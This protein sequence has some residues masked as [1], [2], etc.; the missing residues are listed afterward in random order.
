[1]QKRFYVRPKGFEPLTDGLENRCSIQLSYGRIGAQKY[2]NAANKQTKVSILFKE[3]Q[4]D[5][6]CISTSKT[7]RDKICS[8]YIAG[9]LILILHVKFDIYEEI[10]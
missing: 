8:F 6:F 7:I 3:I 9:N 1:M 2:K 5:L 10:N 4:T